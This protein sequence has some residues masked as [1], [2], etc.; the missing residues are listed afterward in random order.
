V[1]AEDRSE[2]AA[3]RLF[4]TH[5]SFS[6]AA[7]LVL[8]LAEAA[9][10]RTNVPANNY[11]PAASP[12]CI[13]VSMVEVF[14]FHGSSGSTTSGSTAVELVSEESASEERPAANVMVS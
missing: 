14:Y 7:R 11:H 13:R 2:N 6:S 4:I 9:L 3:S 8:A 1:L 10:S 12:A 5:P